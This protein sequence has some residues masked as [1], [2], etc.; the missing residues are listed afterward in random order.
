[1]YDL[2]PHQDFLELEKKLGSDDP[3]LQAFT[4]WALKLERENAKLRENWE[5]IDARRLREL[6]EDLVSDVKRDLG[7]FFLGFVLGGFLFTMLTW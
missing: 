7:V 3:H 6:D 2:P 5:N 4:Y 1:M